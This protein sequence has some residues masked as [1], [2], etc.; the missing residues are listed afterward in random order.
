MKKFD[1]DKLVLL[2]VAVAICVLAGLNLFQGER[3]TVSESEN[4][5]LATMP[6]FT[7][8]D[9]WD[10]SYFSDIMAF[11]SDTFYEREAFVQTSKWMDQFKSLSTIFPSDDFSAIVNPKPNTPTTGEDDDEIPT[12]PPIPTAPPTEPPTEPPVTDPSDPTEPP[13]PVQLSDANAEIT[14]GS[15]KKLTATVG[16]GFSDLKWSS[17]RI[18]LVEIVDNGDG[19]ASVK[20]LAAGTAIVTATVTDESGQTHSV[21]CSVTVKKP[22]QANVE[23]AQEFLPEGLFLYKGAVYTQSW[24]TGNS[25]MSSYGALFDY[26]AKMF[27]DTRVTMMPSPL[28]T[29]TITDPKVQSKLSSQTYIL[30][31]IGAQMPESVNY[32]NLSQIMVEHADEYLFFKSDHHWTH[33]GAYYAYHEFAKSVGLTPTPLANFE[34]KVLNTAMRGSMRAFTAD[35]RVDKIYDTLYAYMPTKSC[36]MDVLVSSMGTFSR[37]YCINTSYRD[38]MAF[39]MGDHGYTVITVPENDPE[40]VCLV[41]KDSYGNAFVPYLTEHY[42]KIIVIDPRHVNMNVYEEFKDAGVDDIIFVLNTS[43][44]TKAWYN[45]FYKAIN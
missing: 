26:Y 41:L 42:G 13:I 22:P 17:N 29:I 34:V 39:M 6:E 10:G 38:Y 19:T 3:P 28:A 15:A 4:R 11:F 25:L 12:L 9:L 36:K 44:C 35:E 16:E 43:Q 33:L 23:D 24:Y 7:W 31:S 1:L 27:P 32:V 37:D 20:A 2:L 45:Y 8:E 18:D 30:N 5:N 21:T 40:M 14:I